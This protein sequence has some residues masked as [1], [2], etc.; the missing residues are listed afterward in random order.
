[1]DAAK[2]LYQSTAAQGNLR[3]QTI[4]LSQ[5][6]RQAPSQNG[7]TPTHPAHGTWMVLVWLVV[8]AWLL[9]FIKRSLTLKLNNPSLITHKPRHKL[10]CS[11]CRFLHSNSYLRC[12]V[13]PTKVMKQEANDCP[14]YWAQD[15][16]KFVH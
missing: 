16:D 15:S 8:L 5:V 10:P 9:R 1:M 3:G 11:S 12:A 4:N 7:K 14:D 13:H 6:P 2:F